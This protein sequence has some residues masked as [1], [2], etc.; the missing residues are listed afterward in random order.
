MG[1]TMIDNS[2]C[3]SGFVDGVRPSQIVTYINALHEYGIAYNEISTG[4]LELLPVGYDCKNII[5]RVTD[6]AELPMA[7][8]CRFGYV[9]LPER[10]WNYAGDID[11]P[12][13]L[14]LSP[15]G[16]NFLLYALNAFSKGELTNISALRIKDDFDMEA[17]QLSATIEIY[18]NDALLPLDICPTDGKLTA[19]SSLIS[20]A[21]AGADSV[22][23]RF[24]SCGEYA[25]LK[26]G[27]FAM[28][29]MF[30]A[31][32]PD[33]IT[34]ALIKCSLLYRMIYGREAAGIL[35]HTDGIYLPF[36]CNA[37]YPFHLNR[38]KYAEAAN[39]EKRGN[40]S[41]LLRR[42][43]SM[44]VDSDNAADLEKALDEFCIKLFNK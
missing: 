12:V 24:G 32:L 29:G 22:T 5:L 41:S 35:S 10:L 34:K 42:L 6:E 17:Y 9:C 20:A 36:N 26:D 33:D 23:M 28:A 15:H 2:L 7:N 25:E 40:P 19:V 13:M 11:S 4:T 14:E 18:K 8:T 21:A 16:S 38:R 43:K 27:A 44:S 39:A 30:S 31:P 3:D 37:E 1:I